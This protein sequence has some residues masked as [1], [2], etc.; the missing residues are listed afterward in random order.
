MH[1][2]QVRYFLITYSFLVDHILILISIHAELQPT[3][4]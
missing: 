1:L 3:I 2:L 4:F